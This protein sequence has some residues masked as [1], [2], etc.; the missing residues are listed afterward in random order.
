MTITAD[1]EPGVDA[2]ER[3]LQALELLT[4]VDI[5]SCDRRQ[6]ELVIAARRSVVAVVDAMM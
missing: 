6:L 3:A 4:I 5:E 2:G 1:A